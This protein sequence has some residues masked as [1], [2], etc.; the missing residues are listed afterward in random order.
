MKISCN[1]TNE[2]SGAA[3]S[4]GVPVIVYIREHSYGLG[5]ED[6]RIELSGETLFDKL[7]SLEDANAFGSIGP[8]EGTD[9]WKKLDADEIENYKSLQ[10]QARAVKTFKDMGKFLAKRYSPKTGIVCALRQGDDAVWV[11]PK[12]TELEWAGPDA[13]WLENAVMSYESSGKKPEKKSEDDAIRYPRASLVRVELDK[14][15]EDK[16]ILTYPNPSSA[17]NALENMQDYC[18]RSG[19]VE[20]LTGLQINDKVIVYT[21]GEEIKSF[22]GHFVSVPL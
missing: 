19:E 11:N 9:A 18:D 17:E 3:E 15:G 12:L 2:A 7:I 1:K 13:E 16:A 20:L 4:K 6:R 21:D 22:L 8:A 14:E 5:D 10:E